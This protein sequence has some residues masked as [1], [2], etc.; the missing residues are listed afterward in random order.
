[1]SRL[2]S[3]S[4]LSYP[5]SRNNQQH[6]CSQILSPWLDQVFPTPRPQLVVIAYN[7]IINHSYLRATSI[8]CQAPLAQIL[9]QIILFL[10][11]YYNII[12]LS[13]STAR[14]SISHHAPCRR[15]ISR[16]IDQLSQNLHH[17]V[18]RVPFLQHALKDSQLCAARIKTK[19]YINIQLNLPE[20]SQS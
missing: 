20:T 17:P 6:S 7:C 16:A 15:R 12:T 5:P 3:Y 4:T 18:E 14:K 11:T 8:L 19:C 13:Q 1:M 10:N 2:Y 9:S